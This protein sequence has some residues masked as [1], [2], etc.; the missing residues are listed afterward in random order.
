MEIIVLG[1][2]I[3]LIIGAIQKILFVA[4]FI[5]RIHSTFWAGDLCTD[6]DFL[7]AK[8]GSP[9]QHFRQ[10]D[11]HTKLNISTFLI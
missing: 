8:C 4:K 1:T 7:Y 10:Y 2:F 5:V 9:R 6:V 3:T 11:V